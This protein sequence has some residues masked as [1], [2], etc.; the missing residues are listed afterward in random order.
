MISTI[1]DWSLKN[2][3][4]VVLAGLVLLVWGGW[5]TSRM[6]VDVFPDLTAPSV[7]IVA[8]AYLYRNQIFDWLKH[9]HDEK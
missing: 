2:R 6:P 9:R 4:F 5:Q 3:L 1:I 7:T 8:V